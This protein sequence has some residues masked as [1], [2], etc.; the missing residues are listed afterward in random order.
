MH[1]CNV[2]FCATNLFVERKIL[3]LFDP[4]AACWFVDTAERSSACKLSQKRLLFSPTDSL[5][6]TVSQGEEFRMQEELTEDASRQFFGAYL[7]LPKPLLTRKSKPSLCDK[8]VEFL[9][10]PCN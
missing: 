5:G 8:V 3:E 4:K 6:F 9:H 7:S 10:K 1:T 2:R